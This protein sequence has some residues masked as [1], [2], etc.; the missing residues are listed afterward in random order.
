[1][2]IIQA[3]TTQYKLRVRADG[4]VAAGA[5]LFCANGRG[6][7]SRPPRY[8][9]VVIVVVLVTLPRRP[10]QLVVATTF[11]LSLYFSTLILY[12]SL[13]EERREFYEKY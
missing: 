9:V 13:H 11:F 3:Y 4:M 12:F 6:W 1:M 5:V 2:D 8:V 10:L 7:F